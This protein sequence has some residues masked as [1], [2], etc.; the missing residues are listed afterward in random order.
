MFTILPRNYSHVFIFFFPLYINWNGCLLFN[1]VLF[2]CNFHFLMWSLLLMLHPLIGLFIFR[3]LGY[4]YQLVVPGQVPCVGL[5]LP[6]RN[7]RLLASCYVGWPSTS[8]VRWLPCIWITVLLK[9]TCVIKVV[10]CLLFFPDWPAGQSLLNLK[11]LRF[12]AAL[13]YNAKKRIKYSEINRKFQFKRINGRKYGAKSLHRQWDTNSGV[14]WEV[15]IPISLS[16]QSIHPRYLSAL[17]NV[18]SLSSNLLQIQH[19]LES[20]SLDILALTETWTKQNQSLEI[21]QGT[22][23]TMGYS[24]VSSH[25]PGRIGGGLGLI[26]KDSIEVKK[27]DAG[28]SQ[29]FEHLTLEL[30]NNSIIAIIY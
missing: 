23:S 10:Q 1:E 21:V 29:T 16:L 18:R 28:I 27:K 17:L 6:C 14:H 20:S 4:P 22:L 11:N 3:V 7:F 2:H 9:C 24:L 5:I 13:D 25:R 19:L 12:T 26:H 15:L 8:L 30:A